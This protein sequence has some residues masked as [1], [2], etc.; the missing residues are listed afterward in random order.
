ML[1]LCGFSDLYG[2]ASFH[3]SI[4]LS[5]PLFKNGPSPASFLFIFDL[6]KQTLNVLQQYNEKNV[7]PVSGVGIRT[8]YLLNASILQY[9]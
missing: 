1:S 9:H 5:M 4:D 2:N 6:Y 7:H 8:H 3:F